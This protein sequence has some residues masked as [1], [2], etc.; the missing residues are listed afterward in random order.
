MTDIE[1]LLRERRIYRGGQLSPP[2]AVRSSGFAELDNALGGGLP[3]SGVCRL[4]S[5]TGIGELR[6]LMPYLRQDSRK[7]I[8]LINP[9]GSLCA[10]FW[11]NAGFSSEQLYA[12]RT[13]HKQ[14]LWCAGQCLQ[15]GCCLA[16]LIWQQDLAVA[17]VK[18][19]QL[20]C[21]KGPCALWLL[22]GYSRHAPS[23]PLT[24]SMS[25]AP[26]PSGLQVSVTKRKG[27]WP[28]GPIL[29]DWR[30]HWPEL[31]LEP[32]PD[33]VHPLPQPGRRQRA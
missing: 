6:L 3:T 25:L 26:A 20:A 30:Q 23:L 24:L 19:L 10:D 17:D 22:Q 15:S 16:V 5:D 33:N 21:D 28:T 8:V 7:L 4:Q 12:V 27:G 32:L 2:A 11:V 31:V 29:L 14:A 1:Q 9:P 13:D 18:R